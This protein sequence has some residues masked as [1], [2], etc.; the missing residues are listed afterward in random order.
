MLRNAKTRLK[1]QT[2][3]GP[4]RLIGYARVS[5]EDQDLRMQVMALIDY[6]VPK[7]YIFVD[8]LSGK[9]LKRPGLQEALHIVREGDVLVAWS[10]DRIGR[11]LSDLVIVSDHIGKKKAQ[12]HCIRDNFDTA[13]AMG[14][15]YFH[16]MGALAELKRRLISER[17]AA[18]IQARKR[19]GA[20]FGRAKL[21]T[22]K[23]VEKAIAWRRAHIESGGRRGKTVPQIAEHFG[24]SVVT[25]RT[26]ILEATGGEK[27]WATGPWAGKKRKR[28]RYTWTESETT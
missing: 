1:K 7:E 13:T 28:K 17:T 6:G 22:A 14:G 12:I 3:P 16:L 27:L 2:T 15:F 11:T 19:E 26:S 8:K 18:S 20:T 24:V 5:T 21:L 25:V 4:G 23:Q 9:S 10:L